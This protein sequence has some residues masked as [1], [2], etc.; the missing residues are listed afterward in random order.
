M[1]DGRDEVRA[2]LLMRHP[3]T[4]RAI[5]D[6]ADKAEAEVLA[7][8]TAKADVQP[9]GPDGNF[10]V[11]LDP[12]RHPFC[13]CPQR[14]HT[15]KVAVLTSGFLLGGSW[16]RGGSGLRRGTGRCDGR[17]RCRAGLDRAEAR[18]GR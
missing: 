12:A 9:A 13:V 1:V 4:G 3:R 10:R 15:P 2:E 14:G 6:D 11:Y 8:G 5:Q 17:L 16:W 18:E 7:I